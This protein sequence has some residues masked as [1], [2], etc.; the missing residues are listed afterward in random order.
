VRDEVSD[1]VKEAL[2]KQQKHDKKTKILQPFH[3][4]IMTTLSTL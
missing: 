4:G 1:Y 3:P 2:K